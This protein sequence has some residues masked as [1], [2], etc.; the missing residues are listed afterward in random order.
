MPI[1]LDAPIVGVLFDPADFRV[2]GWLWLADEHER[3]ASVE[4]YDGDV[5]LG[6]T[7]A[8]TLQARQDVSAKYGLP[9]DLRTAFEIAARHPTALP[10]EPFALTIRVRR[11]DGSRSEPLFHRLLAAPPPERHPQQMLVSRVAKTALGLE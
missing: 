10:R 3:I 6:Q 8:S 5:L 11:H 1:H 4:V 9:A 7:A 2:R